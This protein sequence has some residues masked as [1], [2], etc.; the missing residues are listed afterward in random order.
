MSHRANA[1][2]DR[3]ADRGQREEDVVWVTAGDV[4]ANRPVTIPEPV[5]AGLV[6]ATDTLVQTASNAM[7]AASCLD[8]VR[9]RQTLGIRAGADHISRPPTRGA[10]AH[11]S[12]GT[13]CCPAVA[14]LQAA[15]TAHKP[16]AP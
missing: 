5:R 14:P 12:G 2:I 10:Q 6:D 9:P 8:R 4:Y 1:D 3:T 13:P 15:M 11:V 7:S 16:S